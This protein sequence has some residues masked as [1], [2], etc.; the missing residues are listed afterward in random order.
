MYLSPTP[1]I[2][3]KNCCV[4]LCSYLYV[5]TRDFMCFSLGMNSLILLTVI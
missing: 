5:H 3:N 4:C 2:S 1:F